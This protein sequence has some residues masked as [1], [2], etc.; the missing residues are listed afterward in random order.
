MQLVAQL[1]SLQQS[2]LSNPEQSR[3]VEQRL[4]QEWQTIVDSPCL[5]QSAQGDPPDAPT[6]AEKLRAEQKAWF[7]FCEAWTGFLSS[8]FPGADRA[9]LGLQ[10]LY[11]RQGELMQIEAVLRNRGC[12]MVPSI[13]PLLEPQ[14]G[15]IS[16]E[17][18][19][20]QIEPLDRA[21]KAYVEAHAQ[22]VPQDRNE[23]FINVEQQQLLNSLNALQYNP[24][25]TREQFEEADL[26]LNQAWQRIMKSSCL[27]KTAAGDPPN[28]P[29]SA[30]KLRAEQRAWIQLR[31]AWTTWLGTIFVHQD[32][33]T[34]AKDIT[35]WRTNELTQIEVI[36]H[37]RGCVNPQ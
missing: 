12:Q 4:N 15:N 23:R 37:N 5:S 3:S 33:A 19:A 7:Q 31:D 36:L 32:Q 10:L 26:H 21:L 22:S 35:V 2:P 30:E 34:L 20:A 18:L 25:P 29:V 1:R 17:R 24:P 13:A 8:V 27:E 14:L 6:S 11:E 16:P 9:S 28:A